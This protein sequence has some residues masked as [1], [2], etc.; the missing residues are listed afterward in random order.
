MVVR[1]LGEAVDRLDPIGAGHQEPP[2]WSVECT[3]VVFSW[4]SAFWQHLSSVASEG[5]CISCGKPLRADT[6]GRCLFWLKQNL[7]FVIIPLKMNYIGV[8]MSRWARM[9]ARAALAKCLRCLPPSTMSCL[10]LWRCSPFPMSQLRCV[11]LLP[12]LSE[13]FS[14]CSLVR[15][16]E[17]PWSMCYAS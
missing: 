13:S 5:Y 17:K 2:S 6:L 3:T 9:A 7:S 16:T 1:F 11:S 4:I 8:V 12:F 15:K 10:R 14:F